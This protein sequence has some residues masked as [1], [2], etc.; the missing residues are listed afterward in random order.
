MINK[1]LRLSIRKL[2]DLG[3]E[4]LRAGRQDFYSEIQQMIVRLLE[5]QDQFTQK[6]GE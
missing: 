5:I 1:L 2:S 3:P 6:E 4:L